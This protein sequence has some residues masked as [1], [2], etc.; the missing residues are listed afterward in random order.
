MLRPGKVTMKRSRPIRVLLVVAAAFSM[1]AGLS[2]CNI[3]WRAGTTHGAVFE[4]GA[5][6][7]SINIYRSPRSKLYDVYKVAGVNG[8]QDAL[9]AVGRPPVVRIPLG[10]GDSVGVDYLASKF[11]GYIYGDD[12][13]LRGALLDAQSSR[14]C[15]S[16]T[17]ISRGVYNK[18]WTH[19]SVGCQLGSL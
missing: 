13:D 10:G 19:K 12:S 1:V 15:L 14:D 5:A 17:I 16:L 2:G 9:W 3:T 18:N 6:R 7:G 8:V 4:T 11:H